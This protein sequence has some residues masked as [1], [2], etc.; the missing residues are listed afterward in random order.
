MV[1]SRAMSPAWTGVPSGAAAGKRASSSN[2][3]SADACIAGSSPVTMRYP[4]VS[5]SSL[6]SLSASAA[7]VSTASMYQAQ[8][9][10]SPLSSARLSASPLA[11]SASS[12]VMK[13]ASAMVASIP[14]R[15][16]NDFSG[17]RW[18]A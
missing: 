8:T 3:A 17:F 14:S 5:T 12:G 16:R 6:D 9:R 11:A 18:G 7:S 15:R 13:P 1:L 4:P 2:S 10:A